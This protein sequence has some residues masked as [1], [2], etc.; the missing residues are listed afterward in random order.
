MTL[1]NDLCFM[2]NFL[3]SVHIRTNS[4][5]LDWSAMWKRVGHLCHSLEHGHNIGKMCSHSSGI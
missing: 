2:F 4:S 3:R 1:L 5:G